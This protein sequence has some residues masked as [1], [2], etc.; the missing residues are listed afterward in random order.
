MSLHESKGGYMKRGWTGFVALLLAILFLYGCADYPMKASFPE[1]IR[2]V[3]IP[4]FKN[5][6]SQPGI[7]QEITSKVIQNFIVDGRLSVVPIE[8]ADALLEGSIQQ[9]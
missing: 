4:T 5:N 9:Y 7:D 2:K 8:S 3:A 6:T 1:Y